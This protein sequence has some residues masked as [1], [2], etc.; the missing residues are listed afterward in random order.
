[1]C[2]YRMSLMSRQ[3]QNTMSTKHEFSGHHSHVINPVMCTSA[4]SPFIVFLTRIKTFSWTLF[5]TNMN[6]SKFMRFG[7]RNHK[8]KKGRYTLYL[9]FKKR[10]IPNTHLQ[11]KYTVYPILKAPVYRIPKNPGRPLL[12]LLINAQFFCKK[13]QPN[14]PPTSPH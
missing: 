11:L 14:L 8:L 5:L 10:D 13:D 1:M 12:K 4:L 2:F 6:R 9:K 7:M 3:V